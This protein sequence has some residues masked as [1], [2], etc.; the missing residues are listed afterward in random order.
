MTVKSTKSS[1]GFWRENYVTLDE[2]YV[3][4]ACKY[5]FQRHK[6]SHHLRLQKQVPLKILNHSLILYK[7]LFTIP[8]CNVSELL[9]KIPHSQ[10]RDILQQTQS[11]NIEYF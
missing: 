1:N 6:K 7:I 2:A 9:G 11:N 8:V 5:Y 10:P 3:S 4:E